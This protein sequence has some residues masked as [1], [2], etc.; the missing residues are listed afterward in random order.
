MSKRVWNHPEVP[1]DEAGTQVWRSPA[2][3]EGS[4]LFQDWLHREFP[5]KNGEL[6]EEERE[7][8][9]RNFVKLMGA[10]SALA[11]L[12]L[13]SCRRPESLSLIHI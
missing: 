12:G 4:P 9:R 11:G 1:A 3:L 7:F 2:E 13:A 6:T 8:S 10:S 5:E